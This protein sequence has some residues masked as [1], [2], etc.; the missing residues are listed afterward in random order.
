MF[1]HETKLAVADA[2]RALT[3][4][5]QVNYLQYWGQPGFFI[6]IDPW[7][8]DGQATVDRTLQELSQRLEVS[9]RWRVVRA[10]E[11]MPSSAPLYTRG[12]PVIVP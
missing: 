10:G 1:I 6:Q 8:A 7:S 4:V 12:D 9:I 5:A 2:L 3:E 11:R